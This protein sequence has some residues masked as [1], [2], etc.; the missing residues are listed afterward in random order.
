MP[1]MCCFMGINHSLCFSKLGMSPKKIC[2]GKWVT[3]QLNRGKN[4]FAGEL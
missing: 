1:V 3:K 4:L 2:G